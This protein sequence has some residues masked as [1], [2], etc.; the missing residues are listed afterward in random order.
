MSDKKRGK[1]DLLE[2]YEYAQLLREARHAV[3]DL[4]RHEPQRVNNKQLDMLHRSVHNLDGVRSQLDR[5]LFYENP[6]I[7]DEWLLLYYGTE[8]EAER[9]IM[10]AF[11]PGTETEQ[12]ENPSTNN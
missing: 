9:L 11:F 6:E 10:A 2:H 7:P 4:L 8:E 3:F 12:E 1:M 5:L